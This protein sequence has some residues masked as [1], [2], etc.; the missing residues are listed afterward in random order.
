[1]KNSTWVVMPGFNEEKYIKKVLAKTKKISK[2]VIFVDDGSSDKTYKLACSEIK[3]VLRHKINLGKG[4]ALKTGCK[5]AFGELRATHVIL[6]DSDDQHN[7]EELESFFEKIKQGEELI[8]GIRSIDKTMPIFKRLANKSLSWLLFLLFGKLI[9][10]IPSG[11]KAFS[12]GVFDKINW[13]ARGYEI[14]AEIAAKSAHYKIPFTTVCIST[15]YHDMNKGMSFLDALKL[16]SPIFSWRF[17][18]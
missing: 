14:E 10:D 9:P 3:N 4:A 5:Y 12:K 16:V 11:Y 8:F 17:S 18:L 7:P 2:N 15:I 13:G 6:M 1:M